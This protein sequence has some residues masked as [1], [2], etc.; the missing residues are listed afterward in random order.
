[1]AAGVGQLVVTRTRKFGTYYDPHERIQGIGGERWYHSGHLAILNIERQVNDYAVLLDGKPV[2][3]VVG[4]HKGQKYL[5]TEAD[6]Y[7]PESLLSLPDYP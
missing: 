4:N 5:K 1:V 6:G 7:A 3:V 2:R